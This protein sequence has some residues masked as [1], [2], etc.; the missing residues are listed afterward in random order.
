MYTIAFSCVLLAFILSKY[1][2]FYV[3]I[4]VSSLA[5]VGLLLSENIIG[6]DTLG[7]AQDIAF[8]LVCLQLGY[9]VGM[10]SAAF[11]SSV[12]RPKG[13]PFRLKVK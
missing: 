2:K 6:R 4:P 8:L 13:A 5:A 9:M 10:L 11:R 7:Q 12:A 3:L 1:F